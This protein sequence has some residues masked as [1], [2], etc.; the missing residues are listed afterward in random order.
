MKFSVNDCPPAVT[1][2]GYIYALAFTDGTVKV[3]K[4]RV[5]NKRIAQ[6]AGSG[7][8]FGI[9]IS[10]YWVSPLVHNYSR[11]EKAAIWMARALAP[12]RASVG[13]TSEYFKGVDVDD[14]F[15]LCGDLVEAAGELVTEAPTRT[16]EMATA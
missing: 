13:R 10:R 16:P 15:A 4:S 9:R 8:G 11:L 14:L 5:P 6:H 1:A 7:S 2:G 3:G 12:E